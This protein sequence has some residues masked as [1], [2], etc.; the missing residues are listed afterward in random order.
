MVQALADQ[1][2]YPEPT[3]PTPRGPASGFRREPTG[4]P[5]A[6]GARLRVGGASAAGASTEARRP[7]FHFTPCKITR[8]AITTGAIEPLQIQHPPGVA[9][10][11]PDPRKSKCIC[12][13]FGFGS[14]AAVPTSVCCVQARRS[15]GTW[16]VIQPRLRA[17]LDE[18]F[19]GPAWNGVGR[20]STG[21]ECR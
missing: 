9:A 10:F 14:A 20:Y 8:I 5:A 6:C 18:C 15:R 11:A 13:P 12:S 7:D 19:E 3:S 2:L 16:A 21:M 4:T 17:Q 1:P